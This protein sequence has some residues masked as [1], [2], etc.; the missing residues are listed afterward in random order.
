MGQTG[1]C[2]A[3]S[4]RP[5]EGSQAVVFARCPFSARYTLVLSSQRGDWG[6]RRR[7]ERAL[8]NPRWGFGRRRSSAPGGADGGP[9]RACP[10]NPTSGCH[11]GALTK[12]ALDSGQRGVDG[13]GRRSGPPRRGRRLHIG[14]SSGR[15]GDLLRPPLEDPSRARPPLGRS[16]GWG[17]RVRGRSTTHAAA[18]A[19]RPSPP[20]SRRAGTV[21]LRAG[22]PR[23]SSH[24][25]EMS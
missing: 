10:R 13:P 11:H 2:R 19:P 16:V 12:A 21:G 1:A 9:S 4:G 6:G 14:K 24:S 3:G 20:G 22:M 8:G 15:E 5:G 25:H 7:A 18:P 23:R 17:S